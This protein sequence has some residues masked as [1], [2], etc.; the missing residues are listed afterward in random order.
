VFLPLSKQATSLSP[1]RI[2]AWISL[3]GILTSLKWYRLAALRFS[4]QDL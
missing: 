4:Y 3:P 2:V 1:L